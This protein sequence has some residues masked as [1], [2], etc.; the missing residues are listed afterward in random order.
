MAAEPHSSEA[1]CG[2]CTVMCPEQERKQRER[3]KRL[4]KFEMLTGTENN[5][6]PTADP[7]KTIKE[8]TRPA[9]GKDR[10][11]P[12]DLRPPPVLLQ[13]VR[14]L[15][16]E[17]V[18]KAGYPWVEVYNFVFDRLRS[19]KQDMT[20]QQ[21]R[22]RPC[23]SILE[24]SLRFLIYS[25]YRLCEEPFGSFDPKI[26]DT[27]V[28]ECFSR[29]LSSYELGE[30]RHE[31]EF[32]SLFLLYNL[33]LYKA[34]HHVLLLP[35]SIRESPAVKLAVAVNRAYLERNYVLFFR[36]IQKLSFLQSCAVHHHI[37]DSRQKM[38]QM[39]NHAFSSKNCSYP[40]LHLTHLMVLDSPATAVEL[41]KKHGIA[42]DTAVHFFKTS[43]KN[44]GV[45]TCK[46]SFELIDKKQGNRTV[47][48]IINSDFSECT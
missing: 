23:V 34:F 4:H 2:T 30:H 24:T 15:V 10:V 5:L 20:I 12:S 9:A 39:Y 19:I 32:Q 7:E 27:H 22:G 17:I 41:C 26:N 42:V 16:E 46:H 37:E 44:P 6:V 31:S 11:Q 21:V 47:S 3:Q 25:S 18:P 13:T 36:L 43:F 38:L 1:V 48:D 33:G 40:L 28:Q 8:Y 14:Y 45:L 29:L 35:T